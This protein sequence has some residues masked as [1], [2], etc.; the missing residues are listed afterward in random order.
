VG[1]A[2][3]FV[4]NHTLY[5]VGGVDVSDY[6]DFPVDREYRP[7]VYEAIVNYLATDL[8]SEWQTA[9]FCS[10]ACQSYTP[11]I[12]VGL[13]QSRGWK[14]YTEVEEVCPVITLPDR[15]DIYLNGITKK[16]RHEIRRKLR[17]AENSVQTRW[18]VINSSNDLTDEA[19]ETFIDLHQKSTPDKKGFWN[20]AM[21]NFFRSLIKK[22]AAL[23]WLKLYF[24]EIDGQ[25]AS[26]LLCFDYQNEILLYNSGF[27]GRR[28]GNLSPGIVLISYSIQHAI[29]LGRIRYDFLRG[30]EGYK[31]RFGAV[32]EDVFGVK[33]VK[34]R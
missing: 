13:A 33:I 28:F 29:N 3:L 26:A 27:D 14:V 34:E 17:K 19:I 15:W 22:I 8:A 20:R 2:P 31:F 4:D 30:N 32:T 21:L 10:L 18:Y 9:Y 16:Q 11:E 24:L 6:L 1:L 12:M 25:P 7:Q 23:G 5:F